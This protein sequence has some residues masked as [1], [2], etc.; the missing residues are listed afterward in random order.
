MADLWI[1]GESQKDSQK[2]KMLKNQSIA[3]LKN[4]TSDLKKNFK[5]ITAKGVICDISYEIGGVLKKTKETC[6]EYIDDIKRIP[7][8]K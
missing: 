5:G 4:I 6:H 8:G 3:M 1:K 7:N 2:A